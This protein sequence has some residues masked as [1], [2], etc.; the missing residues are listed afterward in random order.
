MIR[1]FLCL[2]LTVLALA[3]APALADDNRPL[4]VSITEQGGELYRAAWK[5]PTNVE[6]RHLPHL[7]ARSCTV[8]GRLRRWS[9]SL[10][11]WQEEVWRCPRGIVG[12]PISIAYPLANPNLAT[13]VRY[14]SADEA[15]PQTMLLQPQET[16][17]RLAKPGAEGGSFGDFVVLGVEHI[18]IG[19]DHLLFVAGLI[20]IART[21]RRVL[22]TIT[23]FTIAHSVTLA[24]ASLN[25]VRLPIAAIEGVIALSIVFLAVEIVKGPRDTLTWRHPIAVASA[26]GL[27]HGFGFAAVLGEIGLPKDNMLAALFAF[28]LGIEIGQ[29]IFAVGVMAGLRLVDLA[30]SRVATPLSVAKLAG[31]AVG[32]LASFWMFERML[33]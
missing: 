6:A 31:Y 7:S 5:I 10:G 29:V 8:Q 21:P 3:P 1:F 19:I 15:E 9:D 26:F 32:S 33:A 28:N 4:S 17:F 23:G 16:V 12:A 20:F 24:L 25:V 13:I 18:W 22:T 30:G 14:H 27:L 2:L 11:H